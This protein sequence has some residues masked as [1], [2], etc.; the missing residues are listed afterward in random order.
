MAME[1]RLTLDTFGYGMPV[2]APLY[3]RPPIYYKNVETIG[4]TYE[5][6]ADAALNLLPEGLVLPEPAM[7]SLLFIR[8]PWSTLGPYE[9]TILGLSCLWK[10][11]PKFYIVHIVVNSDVPQAAGREIW[12]YPKKMATITIETEGDII[13]G[14]MERPAGNLICSAGIRPETPVEEPPAAGG[15]GLSLRVIPSPEEGAPPSLAELIEVPPRNNVTLESWVGPGW[16]Q[17]H[18][19]SDVDPWH[20]LP[21]KGV[22]GASYRKYHMELG[23]GK[24]IKT[25]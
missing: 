6:D 14:K 12:G 22:M 21:I 16:A 8:Y 10:G 3:A 25:Y 7:A 19:A 17:Y 5:T 24:V 4:I 11:E 18:T 13:W 15:G 23:F 1:G 2:D 20:K 9:E